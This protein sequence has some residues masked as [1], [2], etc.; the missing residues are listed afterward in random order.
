MA[1]P[2]TIVLPTAESL[3]RRG[4][5][6]QDLGRD[7]MTIATTSGHVA[8]GRG[9]SLMEPSLSRCHRSSEFRAASGTSA[10]RPGRSRRVRLARIPSG[11]VDLG[12]RSLRFRQLRRALTQSER[13]L[14]TSTFRRSPGRLRSDRR[15]LQRA[16]I[17]AAALSASPRGRW[18]RSRLLECRAPGPRSATPFPAS[19]YPIPPEAVHRL[20]GRP[21]APY[22]DADLGQPVDGSELRPSIFTACA[23]ASLRKRPAFRLVFHGGLERHEGHV[24]TTMA[25]GLR[26]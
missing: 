7:R 2:S 10:P 9:R 21:R 12:R 24:S 18:Q 23:P 5:D 6:E 20:R 11:S 14:T 17:S 25:F 22:G 13:S 26:A 19:L 3:T 16:V 15:D 1:A 4:A 8:G